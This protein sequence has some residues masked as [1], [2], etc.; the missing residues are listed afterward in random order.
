ML[1]TAGSARPWGSSVAT[2][3]T[4]PAVQLRVSRKLNST[5]IVGALTNLV[6]LQ[7]TS[8]YIRS[9]NG[10]KFVAQAARNRIKAVAAKNS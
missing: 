9:D 1:V 10:A 7:D 4:L 5:D 2:T 8:V 6:I 3:E